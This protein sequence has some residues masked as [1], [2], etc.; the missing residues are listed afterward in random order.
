M[1]IYSGYDKKSLSPDTMG[2]PGIHF[3]LL[4]QFNS[5]L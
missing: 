4:R 1:F 3:N 2:V 5:I